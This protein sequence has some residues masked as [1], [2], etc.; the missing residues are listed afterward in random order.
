MNGPLI[1]W[2]ILVAGTAAVG[3]VACLY[4]IA[5]ALVDLLCWL[6]DPTRAAK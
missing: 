4:V 2:L 6:C 3:L 5:H 1:A